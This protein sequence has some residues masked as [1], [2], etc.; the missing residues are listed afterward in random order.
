MRVTL[1]MKEPFQLGDWGNLN[2]YLLCL[3]VLHLIKDFEFASKFMRMY[4]SLK[5]LHI[6]RLH[7]IYKY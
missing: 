2:F 6:T 7:S 4:K 3:M 1:K 5:L